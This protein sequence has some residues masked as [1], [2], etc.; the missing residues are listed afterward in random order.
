MLASERQTH[1]IRKS[2][3][4]NILRQNIGWF[5]VHESGELNSRITNDISK[6]QDGIGDKLGQFM[7]WFCAFLAGVI[8]GFVHGW[9]LTLVILSISPLLALCA[10]I[11]TKLVGKASGAE[12]KAYAKAGAIAEEVLGAIR[13]VLAFG[14]EEKECKRYERN[15]LAARTRASGRAL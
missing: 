3:Y 9:K 1:R 8:V 5:D 13:T 11:M 2:F 15:L 10:V 14:G 12:L 7:Q 6:I 4:Q